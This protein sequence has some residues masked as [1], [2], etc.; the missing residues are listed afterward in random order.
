MSNEELVGKAL[1][2]SRE[3]LQEIRDTLCAVKGENY[4]D[5][6]E[7]IGQLITVASNLRNKNPLL[8]HA[9]VVAAAS[10]SAV[11]TELLKQDEEAFS[12]D[13]IAFADAAIKAAERI[14]GMLRKEPK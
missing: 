14:T 13:S 7:S 2:E 3:S 1:L 12:K 10:L 5:A 4:A 6:A 8:S 11:I 9:V